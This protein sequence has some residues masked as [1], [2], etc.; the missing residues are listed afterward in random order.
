MPRILNRGENSQRNSGSK[1][2][3]PSWVDPLPSSSPIPAVPHPLA[4]ALPAFLLLLG[5]PRYHSNIYS[6][7]LSGIIPKKYL[8]LPSSLCR[9]VAFSVRG[10]R[11][12]LCQSHLVGAGTGC[13]SQDFSLQ[14]RHLS[15][16]FL[17]MKLGRLKARGWKS[18]HGNEL[19]KTGW[20]RFCS[21]QK[22]KL[23][24]KG[25]DNW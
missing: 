5:M 25:F 19:C 2:G 4:K 21:L 22:A 17:F 7:C 10:K 20:E 1:P 8:F 3:I 15:I 13:P 24:C 9:Y 23:S 12:S 14:H 18:W 6:Q 11:E 16:Y